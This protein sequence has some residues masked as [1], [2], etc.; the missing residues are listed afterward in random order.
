MGLG[1][2]LRQQGRRTGPEFVMSA[3]GTKRTSL[4]CEQMSAFG[5]KRTSA[6]IVPM[7]AYDP[8]RKWCSLLSH[9]CDFR[10]RQFARSFLKQM[11]LATG[12]DLLG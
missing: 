10:L 12:G 6:E 7:S 1:I 3:I 11:L 9:F 8:K 2:V 4:G 5:A